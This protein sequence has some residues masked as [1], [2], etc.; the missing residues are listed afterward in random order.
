M[1][2]WDD[3]R[4]RQR[5][6]LLVALAVALAGCGLSDGPG[7]LI[8]DPGHYDAY[9]CNDLV[10]RWKVLNERERELRGLIDKA[11]TG[12][13]GTVIGSIAYGPDYQ[14]VLTEKKLVQQQAAAKNCE[15]VHSFQ[16]DQTIR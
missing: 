6:A 16:S 3:L 13:G 14:A 10:A 1:G 11:S 15:L 7:T 9:H 2:L 8:V 12:T 4:G 5:N